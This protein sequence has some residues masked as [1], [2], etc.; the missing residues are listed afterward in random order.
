MMA[1]VPAW[2]L[3]ELLDHPEMIRFRQMQEDCEIQ[4][5][6]AP[7]VATNLSEGD[8]PQSSDANPN[9]LEDF[10]RLVDVAARKKPKD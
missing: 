4:R 9:H 8:A 10:T 5:R 1:V 3:S 6:K 2:K 7:K